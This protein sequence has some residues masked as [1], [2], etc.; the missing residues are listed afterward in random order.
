MPDKRKAPAGSGVRRAPDGTYRWF[1]EMSML[2]HPQ[3]LFT[4]WK[5]LGVVFG[6]VWLVVLIASAASDTLYNWDGALALTWGF[7]LLT[8]ADAVIA[9]LVYLLLAAC[10]RWR[11]IL[12]YELDDRRVRVV[13][14]PLRFDRAQARSWLDVATDGP[15]G[16]PGAQA[17]L[18][19]ARGGG[20]VEREAVRAVTAQPE[21]DCVTLRRALGKT[22]IYAAPED[23]DAVRA[24]LGA[25]SAKGGAA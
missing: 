6:A 24:L 5:V 20:T 12:L 9:A 2:R 21:R 17:L 10:C 7:V 15:E 3:I 22:R 18:Q 16:H 1:Y 11:S 4:T 8:L 25:P 23:F 13:Q 19:A 14:T